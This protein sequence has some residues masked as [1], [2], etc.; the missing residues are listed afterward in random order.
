MKINKKNYIDMPDSFHRAVLNSLEETNNL[1][2]DDEKTI[3]LKPAIAF[4]VI[5]IIIISAVVTLI[6]TKN[7]PLDKQ[8]LT[9]I[10]QSTVIQ[11]LPTTTRPAETTTKESEVQTTEEI[12]VNKTQSV[13]KRDN[14]ISEKQV[15]VTEEISADTTVASEPVNSP[16]ITDAVIQNT[17]H[18]SFEKGVVIVRLD[19]RLGG[20]KK[21][22]T[23]DEFPSIG[24]ESITDITYYDEDLLSLN[25]T[26]ENFTQI[27]KFTLTDKSEQAVLDAVEGLS[28]M[29]G[30][31]N[32]S[33]NYYSYVASSD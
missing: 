28:N 31:L 12:I 9:D 21:V 16:E 3:I 4:S 20:I 15:A 10:V 6:S 25:E 1:S 26:P 11:S 2:Y 18:R 32:T 19:S 22:H 23:V 17:T 5:L 33:P 8:P 30:V 27:L 13:V 7:K 24:V 29:K 14:S